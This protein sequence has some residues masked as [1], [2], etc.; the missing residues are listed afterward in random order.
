VPKLDVV[1]ETR[2]GKCPASI[3]TPEG[4]TGPLPAVIFFMDGLGIRPVIW[5]MAQRLADGGYLVLVPDLFYRSG[6]YEPMDPAAIFAD[7]ELRKVLM[8]KFI[9][10]LNRDRKVSDAGAFVDYLSSRSDVLGTRYGAVGYCMGGN[11]AL[12][13]AG[14]YGDRFAAIASFHGGNLATLEPDSPHLF[15]KNIIGAVYVGGAEDDSSFPEEQKARLEQALTDAGVEH[16][17]ESYAGLHGF[18]VPDLPTFNALAAER[19]W[20]AL[21]ELFRRRLTSA[22]EG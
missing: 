17:N 8:T 14:A 10:S 20:G 3:F 9:G 22:G 12:A 18:A 5:Q 19:S 16:W 4:A 15:V 1:V 11:T 21:F 2:D 7:P 13:A 6:G